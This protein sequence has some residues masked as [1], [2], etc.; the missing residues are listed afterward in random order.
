M[1]VLDT[2]KL[3]EVIKVAALNKMANVFTGFDREEVN[4]GSSKCTGILQYCHS[5]SSGDVHNI[6]EDNYGTYSKLTGQTHFA[7]GTA[8]VDR[9]LMQ[10]KAPGEDNFEYWR[11]G[12]KTIN[13]D[14]KFIQLAADHDGYIGYDSSG[15]LSDSITDTR[16]LIV[17][18]PLAAYMYL[19]ADENAVVWYGDERHGDVLSGQAHLLVHQMSKLGFMVASGLGVKGLTD[20]VATYTGIDAGNCGDED[21]LMKIAALST[22]PA[23]Y[24]DGANHYWKISDDDNKVGL[25]SG[26]NASWNDVSGASA[27]LTSL[28]SGERMAINWLATNNKL[29]PIV[30]LIGQEVYTSRREAQRKRGSAF[31]RIS[32]AG[33][34]GQEVENICSSIIENAAG[35]VEAGGDNEVGY[36]LRQGFPIDIH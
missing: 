31:S 34:P 11:H 36:D 10:F 6:G 7:D 27:I 29:A 13:I 28:S 2:I 33:L 5:A 8:L 12:E 9:S 23:L 35:T 26:G 30:R 25:F 3:S 19:N 22:C 15:D 1:A 14:S 16:E 20:G 32:I 17:R 18:T 21:I 24:K 4:E